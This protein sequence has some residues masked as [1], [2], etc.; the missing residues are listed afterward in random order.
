MNWKM[1]AFSWACN[2]KSPRK[3]H[4]DDLWVLGVEEQN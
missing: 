3:G 1:P 2:T 4:G